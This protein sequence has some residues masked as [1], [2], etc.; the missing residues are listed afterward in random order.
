M[1]RLIPPRRFE[2]TVDSDLMKQIKE[3]ADPAVWKARDKQAGPIIQ[4]YA[5]PSISKQAAA[6]NLNPY[7]QGM[8]MLKVKYGNKHRLLDH[9]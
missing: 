7:S 9:A 5:L 3:K 6:L 2:F 8:F 1:C 4:H